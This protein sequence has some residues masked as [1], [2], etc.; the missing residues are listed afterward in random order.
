MKN[1]QIVEKRQYMHQHPYFALQV[2]RFEIRNSLLSIISISVKINCKCYHIVN[3]STMFVRLS[4]FSFPIALPSTGESISYDFNSLK[5]I[6]GTIE[7]GFKGITEKCKK[8]YIH[9]KKFRCT[10][11]LKENYHGM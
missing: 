7:Y 1:I 4:F 9:L 5:D 11:P 8:S 6:N 2:S 10:L 3:V